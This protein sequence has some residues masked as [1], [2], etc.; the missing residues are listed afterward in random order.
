[1]NEELD[2]L[3]AENAKL[4]DRIAKLENQ[5]NPKPLPE[6]NRGP[7]DYT[8]GFSMPRNAME[9]M[10][11]SDGLIND[12]RADS[13]KAN[14]INPPTPSQ[15]QPTQRFT[16]NWVDGRPLEPPPGQKYI[17]AMMNAQDAI[18]REAL[19]LRIAQARLSK[20]K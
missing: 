17:D 6:S 20:G 12:L 2:E 19:A 15:P 1:M 11:L 14:P 10:A 9:A 16:P 8:E 7:V 4:T 18:D 13:R 5:L 3:K